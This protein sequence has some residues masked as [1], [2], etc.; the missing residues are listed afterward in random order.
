[1]RDGKSVCVG[2]LIADAVG[3]NTTMYGRTDPCLR[4]DRPATSRATAGDWLRSGS[5][6]QLKHGPPVLFR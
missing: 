3:E 5:T 2:H 6:A 4:L 1:V